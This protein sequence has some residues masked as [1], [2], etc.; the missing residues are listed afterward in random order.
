MPRLVCPSWRWITISGAPS[1]GAVD[2][3]EQR[4]ERQLDP[5]LEPWFELLPGP[6]VHADLAAAAALAASDQQRSAARVEV[7]LGECERFADA[8]A[9]AP[10][11]DD[12]PRSRRPWTPSPA[13][14]ITVTISSIVG[15]S[16]G[17]RIPSFRGGRA[18]GD[19]GRGGGGRR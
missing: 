10:E 15:G 14:R 16:A 1:R 18:G 6:V 3:P 12:E 11:H 4:P 17:E 2:A 8:Q 13:W 5:R 19:S 9:S 7:G